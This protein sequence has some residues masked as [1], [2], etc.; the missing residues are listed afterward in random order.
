MKQLFSLIIGFLVLQSCSNATAEP[1]TI[2]ENQSS[3]C[4]T[5]PSFDAKIQAIDKALAAAAKPKPQPLRAERK[6]SNKTPRQTVETATVQ[7][8]SNNYIVSGNT[9]PKQ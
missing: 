1:T 6:A 9:P 5:V 4:D 7:Q 8:V 2:A 3:Q